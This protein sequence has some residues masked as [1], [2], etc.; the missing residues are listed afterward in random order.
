MSISLE[1]FYN[2]KE[3]GGSSAHLRKKIL[4]ILNTADVSGEKYLDIGIGAGYSTLEIA[5]QINAKEIYGIDISDK[6]VDAAITMGIIASKIDINNEKLPFPD[7]FFDVV[8]GFEIIEHLTNSDNFLS[9]CYRVLKPGGYFL[10]SSPNIGSWLS[11]ISLILGY[12]PPPYEVSFEHRIGKPFGKRIRLPLAEKPIGHIKPYNLRALKEHLEI[13]GFNIISF[14]STRHI[15]GGKGIL[16][17]L[18]VLD[19]VFS[20]VFKI[21]A[22]GIIILARKHIYAIGA[23]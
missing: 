6:A 4:K 21:Y 13:I 11:I 8:T 22:S 2:E 17:L 9:E 7:A 23:I 19:A 18:D 14:H 15:E 5:N 10:V 1:K 3:V 16:R 12:L 20:N